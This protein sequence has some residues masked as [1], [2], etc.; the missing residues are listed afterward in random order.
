LI[1]NSVLC[2]QRHRFKNHVTGGEG[3]VTDYDQYDL[4]ESLTEGLQWQDHPYYLASTRATTSDWFL[5]AH[6]RA[7]IY[8]TSSPQN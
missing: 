2:L 4:L 3:L 1:Y 8:S 5:E 6:H 7:L